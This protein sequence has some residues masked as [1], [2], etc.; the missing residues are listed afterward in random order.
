VAGLTPSASAAVGVAVSP[1]VTSNTYPGMVTLTITGLTN[2]QQVKVQTYLDL[3]SNGVV[4]PGEPVMDVFNLKESGVTVVGGITNQNIPYD[5]NSSTSVITA[6]L[7]FAPPL[8]NISGQKIYRVIS[9]PG[10]AFTP[11]TATIL[12]TN[13]I[14]GQTASGVVYS[15]GVTPM[16]N[17]VV[18][19]LT[20]TNQNYVASTVADAAGHYQL[21]L[22][23]GSYYLM[24]ACPGCYTDQGQMP[25][26]T[27][28]N[29]V[30]VTNNLSLTNG[31]VTIA[32][33]VYDMSN[34][35]ALGGIFLQAQSGS[36]FA[37]AFTDTNGNY[38]VGGTSNNWK[39]RISAERLAR[40]G[41][42]S[43]QGN[44][45]TVNAAAGNVSGADI[46][47]Y[48]GNAMFYGQM[49]TNNQPVPNVAVEANDDSQIYSSK[50]YTDINGN[51]CVAV[52]VNTNT[53]P[54]NP[55]W[56]CSPSVSGQW[57]LFNNFV[58]N[59]A[60]NIP[61]GTNTAYPLDFVGLPVTTTISGRL[62]NSLGAPIVG[63]SVGGN[64]TING[65]QYVTAF[66]DT[67]TNGAFTFSAA[68]SAWY[69]NANC[70]GN[71][72]LSSQNYYEPGS[73]VVTVPPAAAGLT[74]VAYPSSQP[75]LGQPLRV[76]PTQ[77]DFNLYGAYSYNYT[78]Q[79]STNLASTNWATFTIIS[80]LSSSPWLIQD[81]AAN[82]SSA[83]F[84]RVV[85]G[86]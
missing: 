19:A 16:P 66:V 13:A 36:L 17:A 75:L 2:Y 49:T 39:F 54:A 43:L 56:Y 40:R 7:S 71:H 29:D 3:N 83:R 78:V 63:V 14:L 46:G 25:L 6:T 79:T 84:Y 59:S 60:D 34:S 55:I 57:Q 8:E 72:G 77:F 67:D 12:V 42:L 11:V 82:N 64:A 74:L 48:R 47:L 30:N 73:L 69:V 62:V 22:T 9:N 26:V 50:G 4:D 38:I 23:P 37:I 27:M 61:F 28:V 68:S 86:P 80:N 21:P 65:L 20:E 1:A 45:L 76:S 53:L 31:T 24:P 15:N 70:C 52:L 81:N 41:Y 33:N 85:S 35:N 32:G 10:G 51:Y 44:E 58:F 5:S 18:V